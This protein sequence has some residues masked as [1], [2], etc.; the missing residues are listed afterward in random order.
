M[1]ISHTQ[2][3]AERIAAQKTCPSVSKRISRL[4][5]ELWELAKRSRGLWIRADISP[6]TRIDET[7]DRWGNSTTPSL[8]IISGAD[9]SQC[10]S[11]ILDL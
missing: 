3:I 7:Q 8:N 9:A 2:S 10:W 4:R 5:H 1:T 6:N 11:D